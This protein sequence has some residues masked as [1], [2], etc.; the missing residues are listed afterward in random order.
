M[1][2]REEVR[3]ACRAMNSLLNELESAVKTGGAFGR[4][5]GQMS[6]RLHRAVRAY[7]EGAINEAAPQI[8]RHVHKLSRSKGRAF[9]SKL[10]IKNLEVSGAH[11]D[12][13]PV[14]VRVVSD[15]RPMKRRRGR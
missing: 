3:V 4:A 7:A 15:L 13:S 8:I 12:L 11:F 5:N 9:R 10:T 2:K 6:A 14:P 1:T